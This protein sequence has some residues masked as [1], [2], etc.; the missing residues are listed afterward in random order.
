MK[1]QEKNAFFFFYAL[2]IVVIRVLEKV[3]A[4]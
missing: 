4:L 1:Y 3:H 2:K